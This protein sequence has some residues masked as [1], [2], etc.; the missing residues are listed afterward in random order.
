MHRLKVSAVAR[1]VAALGHPGSGIEGSRRERPRRP[2]SSK[3][4]RTHG[5]HLPPP[6]TR[7]ALASVLGLVLA[8]GCTTSLTNLTPTRALEP[9]EVQ[10]TAAG[11][12]QAGT[13]IVRQSISAGKAAKELIESGSDETI[14]EESVRDL[15]DGA[16]VW[17]LFPPGAG[18][19]FMGRVGLVDWL[20]GIDIGLRTDTKILKADLKV[21]LFDSLDGRYALSGIVGYGY[22]FS[23]VDKLVSYLTLTSFSRHDLDLQLSLGMESG[24]YFKAY[25]NPRIMISRISTDA[26]LPQAISAQLPES[27]RDYDP[28]KLFTDAGL[29]YYGGTVGALI[30]YENLFLAL[31]LNVLWLRFRPVVLEEVRRFDSLIICPAAAAVLIW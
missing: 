23:F 20:G 10:L 24:S 3:L 4:A 5:G 28:R 25:L 26:R 17:L 9:G 22:H 16:L 2:E 14:D 27:L 13:G 1:R 18:Y 12:A 30:G 7:A 6:R 21:Q 29:V 11:Q 15:V 8:A 19:E 31:E